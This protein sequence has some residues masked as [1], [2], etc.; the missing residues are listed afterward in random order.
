MN[1]DKKL[2]ICMDHANAHLIEFP[3]T[4]TELMSIIS[5]STHP[6]NE[7]TQG[8]NENLTHNKEQHQHA[9]YYKKLGNAIKKYDEVLLFGPTTAKAELLNLIKNDHLF[10][11][12]KIEVKHTDKMT[13]HQQQIFVKEYFS[14]N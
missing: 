10:E 8:K 7:H 9:E 5:S 1:T 4:G 12:I 2:G 11:K 14:K 3:N 13:D 6:E